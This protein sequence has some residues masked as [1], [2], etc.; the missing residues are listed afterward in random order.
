MSGHSSGRRHRAPLARHRLSATGTLR[1][2][3]G[4]QLRRNTRR[5]G[6]GRAGAMSGQS[7]MVDRAGLPRSWPGATGSAARVPLAHLV[8]IRGRPIPVPASGGRSNGLGGLTVDP[9]S[10]TA[11][12]MAPIR[13]RIAG[14]LRFRLGGWSC[15]PIADLRLGPGGGATGGAPGVRICRGHRSIAADFGSG[16]IPPRDGQVTVGG[17][18][19]RDGG[20]AGTIA[21]TTAR[22]C[23]APIVDGCRI[24]VPDNHSIDMRKVKHS[25]QGNTDRHEA[26][27]LLRHRTDIST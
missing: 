16:I 14:S 20:D 17:H 11:P 7:G 24:V 9:G 1:N 12:V 13:G 26:T 8:L 5:T 15:R 2:A 22:A 25:D 27:A 21:Q 4:D 23:A 10:V 19:V 6:S 18:V 3:A